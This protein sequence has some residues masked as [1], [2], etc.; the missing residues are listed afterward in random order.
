MQ[1][2]TPNVLII[3]YGKI[4]KIKARIWK[5]CGV[6]VSV[7]D[8][9]KERVECARVDGFNIEKSLRYNFI[10]ICTPSSKHI[11][12]L[13]QIIS[14]GVT[15][16][17]V[18]VEK[19]LFNNT[20]EK[21]TLDELL[22]ID[23]SL[24]E[25]I[26]V[27]E[28]YYKSKVIQILQERLLKKKVKHLQITMSKNR[29]KDNQD[30]RFIDNDI[31]AYGIE[32]PHILAILGI[33]GKNV[34]VM[35]VNKNILYVDS[36]DKNNQ[37][38]FIE[39]VTKDDTKV[40]ITSFL[41][42]FKVSPENKIFNNKIIDRSLLIEGDD[43]SY[44]IILDP[45]PSKGRLLTE[46]DFGNK[47]ILMHD[48]MLSE[49]ISNMISNNIADG[50]KLELAIRHSEHAMSLFNSKNIVKIKK[51]DNHVHNS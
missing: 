9:T 13:K 35:S 37:G 31:G 36:N 18:V 23:T 15:F 11:E 21:K 24:H 42:D 45:H 47:S 10:D 43:F 8:I 38:I 22:N 41:G 3:G 48:D 6:N 25:K 20:Q 12:V 49:N 28:Q 26:I 46:L 17:R 40:V 33:L 39:Y 2:L 44:K 4:G 19:P 5:R 1:Q 34:N 30:G 32:L 51:E 27:N 7:S 14:D 29:K 50:C 16:N